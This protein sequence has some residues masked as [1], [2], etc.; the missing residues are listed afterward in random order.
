MT[1]DDFPQG[2]D[3]AVAATDHGRGVAE[4]V[5]GDRRLVL[6]ADDR[7]RAGTGDGGQLAG[8]GADPTGGRGDH[9]G[10]ADTRL[11]VPHV[12]GVRRPVAA[13]EPQPPPAAY[14]PR[15]RDWS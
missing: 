10:V 1:D 8:Y 9:H 3:P 7:D 6:G 12:G 2:L 15:W 13:E 4:L 14:P 11:E 5:D